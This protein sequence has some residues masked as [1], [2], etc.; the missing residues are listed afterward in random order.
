MIQDDDGKVALLILS[1]LLTRVQPMMHP[2]CP[3][4][5]DAAGALV[6]TSRPHGLMVRSVVSH[7]Y[8]DFADSVVYLRF[9]DPFHAKWFEASDRP[10]YLGS[11]E[12]EKARTL[13]RDT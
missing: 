7:T 1:S 4:F 10:L 11:R 8:P 2:S 6:L 13:F 12:K 9:K 3:S 5:G